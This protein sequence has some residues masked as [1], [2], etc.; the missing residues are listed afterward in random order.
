MK[1]FKKAKKYND[2]EIISILKSGGP[3]ESSV[4]EYLYKI[5][6]GSI[7]QLVIKQGGNTFEAEDVFQ[8][9]LITFYEQVK[10]GKYIRHAKIK[11][12]LYT[13]AK[14]NWINRAKRNNRQV[15]LN[16]AA[17]EGKDN[18]ISANEILFQKEMMVF[19]ESIINE[20]GDNCQKILELSIYKKVAMKEIAEIMQ[21]NNA[22]VA[23]NKKYKCIEQLK[24]I[25]LKSAE[26]S[27]LAKELKNE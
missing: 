2:E 10:N 8:E 26:F 13:I 17:H 1:L 4:L 15:G 11:T 24:K 19:A 21:F 16:V 6:F 7:K 3:Q 23:R 18:N 25:I 22:Q 27:R 14:N 20:L 9:T 12:Y 5:H